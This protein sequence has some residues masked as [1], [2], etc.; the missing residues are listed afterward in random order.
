MDWPFIQG[1]ANGD[2][3]L[4]L[5]AKLWVCMRVHV[6][7]VH[8]CCA[9]VC[10]CVCV[11]VCVFVCCVYFVHNI[12]FHMCVLCICMHVCVFVH[13]WMKCVFHSNI[14]TLASY[15]I[16]CI[17]LSLLLYHVDSMIIWFMPC[18]KANL[19]PQ[20]SQPDFAV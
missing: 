1:L 20:P 15:I 7:V 5:W 8:V 12:M 17:L 9:C 19:L 13:A 16:L 10:M 2:K 4:Q 11:C 14:S 18:V 6:C 3:L